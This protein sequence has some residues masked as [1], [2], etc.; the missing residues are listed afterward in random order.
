MTTGTQRDYYD[1]L[2]VSRDAS[3]SDIKAAYRRLA[4]KYHPDRNP[5]DPDAEEV[6]EDGAGHAGDSEPHEPSHEDSE[7]LVVSVGD[8]AQSLLLIDK[9]L[10]KPDISE[11]FRGELEGYK[12]DMAAGEFDDGDHRYIR[13]LY[14]RLS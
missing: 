8:N 9:M 11:D 6:H 1:I 4:V 5:D 3:A 13:A 12:A 14:D 7:T 2:G 10:A